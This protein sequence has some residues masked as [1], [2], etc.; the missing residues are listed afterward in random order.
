MMNS[1]T[2]FIRS[3]F[4]TFQSK[5]WE[6][7]HFLQKL[8]E[9]VGF[10]CGWNRWMYDSLSSCNFSNVISGGWTY[11]LE[12]AGPRQRYCPVQNQKADTAQKVDERLLWSSGEIFELLDYNP[13]FWSQIYSV[14]KCAWAVPC[15]YFLI[16]QCLHRVWPW[17]LYDLDLTV[18]LLM[19][20][21]PRVR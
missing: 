6:V 15:Y 1:S 4:T 3:S 2:Y 10:R 12:S 7:S 5:E 8:I 21:I 18:R 19:R 13:E 9:I 14:F 17:L 20:L 16:V 11:K